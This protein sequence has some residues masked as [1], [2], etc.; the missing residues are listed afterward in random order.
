MTNV[1]VK[2]NNI[3]YI[4]ILKYPIKTKIKILYKVLLNT[5]IHIQIKN[6]KINSN[7][8][9]QINIHQNLNH[10]PYYLKTNKTNKK[11][12][13]KIY[14]YIHRR[15]IIKLNKYHTQTVSAYRPR[16]RKRPLNFHH[17]YNNIIHDAYKN[18]A[19][20]QHY[21]YQYKKEIHN[22]SWR[23]YLNTK[24]PQMQKTIILKYTPKNTNQHQPTN[25]WKPNKRH[26]DHTHAQLT[27]T[28]FGQIKS[29]IL[30]PITHQKINKTFNPRQLE[31]INLKLYPK[32]QF[33]PHIKPKIAPKHRRDSDYRPRH[34]T[35]NK[36]QT[37][38][39]RK[40]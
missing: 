15:H 30:L 33:H 26:K 3:K 23:K 9:P 35:H 10:I 8:Q 24:P 17:T 27:S 7:A 20:K 40:S 37:T 25:K 18:Y 31:N 28:Q 19:H 11:K 12:L 1:A 38:K 16:Q 13:I 4:Y 14:T 29:S 34:E 5:I 32:T 39:K 36:Y 6:N 2:P 21:L 22:R